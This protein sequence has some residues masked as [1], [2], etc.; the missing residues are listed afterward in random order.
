MESSFSASASSSLLAK[1]SPGPVRTGSSRAIAAPR[2]TGSRGKTKGA[3]AAPVEQKFVDV[4]IRKTRSVDGARDPHAAQFCREFV[5]LFGNRVRNWRKPRCCMLPVD[6][7][8]TCCKDSLSFNLLPGDRSDFGPSGHS[9]NI[10]FYP[11]SIL[12]GKVPIRISEDLPQPDSVGRN[13]LWENAI[14]R[15]F[16]GDAILKTDGFILGGK[17]RTPK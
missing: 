17:S 12:C 13:R 10:L 3:V 9:K 2:I 6:I 14:T 16:S 7:V 4:P 15:V 11:R 1:S 5:T 8:H